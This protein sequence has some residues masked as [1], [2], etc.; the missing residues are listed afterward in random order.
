MLNSIAGP[1]NFCRFKSAYKMLNSIA[2]PVLFLSLQKCK[3]NA[4]QYCRAGKFLSLRLQLV[5]YSGPTHL[6]PLYVP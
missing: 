6:F 5:K 4:E 3:Q 1:V 2:E